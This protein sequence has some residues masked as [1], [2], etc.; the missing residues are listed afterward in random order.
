MHRSRLL[1][2]VG[3]VVGIVGLFLTSLNT[4]GEDLLPALNQANPDF[5]DGIPTIWGGLDAWAQVALVVLILVVLALAL[6]PVI[7]EVMHRTSGVIV[8]VIGLALFAYAIV[9]WLDASDK[10]DS[11]QEAFAAAA[12]AGAI[13][14]AFEVST[15]PLGYLLLLGGTAVV[16]LAGVLAVRSADSA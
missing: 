11:L 2:I 14:A 12:G 13:P 16:A 6:R 15:A 4:D 1:A 3:V 8:I 10:A 5:P 7:Q 9:K